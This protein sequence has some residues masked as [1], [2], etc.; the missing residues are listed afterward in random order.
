MSARRTL[1][2]GD[3]AHL[4]QRFEHSRVIRWIQSLAGR[5]AMRRQPP[6]SDPP[7]RF[8]V[9]SRVH[10]RTMM[11]ASDLGSHHG[12]RHGGGLTP[13]DHERPRSSLALACPRLAGHRGDGRCDAGGNKALAGF[14]VLWPDVEPQ[15]RRCT[16]RQRTAS[17]TSP[18]DVPPAPSTNCCCRCCR[19]SMP[20]C[21]ARCCCIRWW[22]STKCMLP[23]PTWRHCFRPPW[24][25]R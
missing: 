5:Q 21:A 12:R 11:Q 13:Q 22:W 1:P 20:T 23:T 10:V 15:D 18:P 2:E 24:L 19:P 8:E 7:L 16:G 9:S 14:E 6:T 17:A 4:V 3:A 25:A